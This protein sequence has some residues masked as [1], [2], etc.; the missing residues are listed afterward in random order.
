MKDTNQRHTI[1]LADKIGYD[2]FVTL[3]GHVSPHMETAG[4]PDLVSREQIKIRAWIDP[5]I[6][7][8]LTREGRVSLVMLEENGH[9][10]YKIEGRLDKLNKMQQTQEQ[11][12]QQKNRLYARQVLYEL[13]ITVESVQA[14]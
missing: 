9:K 4:K 5:Q 10:V 12:R 11:L 13:L 8:Q 6:A 3:D 14:M 7:R 1:N 2:F